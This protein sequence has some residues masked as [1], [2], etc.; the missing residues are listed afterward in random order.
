MGAG[1]IDTESAVSAPFEFVKNNFFTL[2]PLSFKDIMNL[3]LGIN[4][5]P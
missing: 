2:R 1:S 5:D 4:V 3:F